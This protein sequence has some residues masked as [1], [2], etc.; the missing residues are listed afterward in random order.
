MTHGRYC[1][2]KLKDKL[3]KMRS[4]VSMQT[5]KHPKLFVIMIM[6]LLNI[7]ILLIAAWIALII[8]DGFNGYIDALFNGA[9]KWLLTPNAILEVE[10]PETLALSVAVLVVGLVLFTGAIIGIATNTLKD[11]F[12][13]KDSNSGMLR[14]RDHI[15]ILN[16]NNEVPELIAD[17]IYVRTRN[18]TIV[19]MGDI[20]KTFAEKQ[21]QQALKNTAKA[22]KIDNL[23]VFVKA[24]DPL[25]KR[26]LESI[27]IEKAKAVLIMSKDVS[28]VTEQALSK[29]DLSTIRILLSLGQVDFETPPVLVS[30]VKDINTKEKLLNLSSKVDTLKD[31]TIIPVCF[32]RRLGQIIA[33]SIIHPSI[34]DVYLSLFSFEGS[35]IYKVKDKSFEE[36][37]KHHSHAIP[38]A[39]EK[40]DVFVLS[41]NNKTKLHTS[42]HSFKPHSLKPGSFDV[43]K[44]EDVYIIGSNNKLPFIEEAFESYGRLYDSPVDVSLV[45][46]EA[47]ADT[48]DTINHSD[49]PV[50]LILLSD[51]TADKDVYDAN[52]FN[53]LIYIETHLKRDSAHVIVELLDPKNAPL[54][55]DFHVENTIISNKIVS[56]LLSKLA[57]FPSTANFYENLLTIE[58]S[59]A[60]KD[61]YAITIEKASR[62][63]DTSYPI[64][65]ESK[66]AFITTLYDSMDKHAIPFGIVRNKKLTIL[67]DNLHDSK[68]FTLEKTDEIVWMKL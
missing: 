20:D 48:I 21:I 62:T 68:P 44:L 7:V 65:F 54:I 45:S 34:E 30:E 36:V 2:K 41:E 18:M 33:Q 57:L 31:Y 37:L 32:D 50:T 4:S 40:G 56:L 10:D 8:N 22:R 19:L 52:V 59:K 67:E 38:L 6:V 51:E 14:V 24:G 61:D 47:L 26:D 55:K 58:P 63:F 39:E 64:I 66:K 12:Q 13:S 23:N 17:L 60:G 27:S 42:E 11:Y 25:L 49:T 43:K 29:S 5:F 1:M 16:W 3:Q 53:A 28:A 15:V 46:M 9:V 35:E